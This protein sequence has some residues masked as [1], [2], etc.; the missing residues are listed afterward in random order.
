[1][2]AAMIRRIISGLVLTMII[3]TVL[4]AGCK[5]ECKLNEYRIEKVRKIETSRETR[6]GRDVDFDKLLSRNKDVK[7]WIYLKD[8]EIDYPVVQAED[9]DYYLHRNIDGEYA[10]EGSVFIDAG[11]DEPFE[12]MNTVIYGH[13]MFSGAMFQNIS[14][15][16]D[17]DY[18][19]D[20][21]VF[22]LE[23]PDRSYDL[24][25]FAYCNE[26]DDSEIYRQ[27]ASD[28]EYADEFIDL[29]KTKAVLLSDEEPKLTDRFVTLSTCAYNYEG[30]RHQVICV[31]REPDVTV[32][33][34][35]AEIGKPFFNKWLAAQIAVSVIMIAAAVSP[36]IWRRH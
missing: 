29:I 33:T 28:P 19:D 7:G 24:K 35:S 5:L 4:A 11:C 36:L 1:M 26:P 27:Y 6:K 16:R 31:I 30:A 34:V 21:K 9:N 22:I 20:H 10:Y 15:F 8:S 12:S 2:I 14:E 23:T 25:V 18:F 3:V 17:A 32:K 13:N